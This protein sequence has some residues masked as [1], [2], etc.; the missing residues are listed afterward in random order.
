MRL[1]PHGK[2]MKGEGE[3]LLDWAAIGPFAKSKKIRGPARAVAALFGAIMGGAS[4]LGG[5][6]LG[7]AGGA[8]GAA[9]GSTAGG[10]G[11][12]L[13]EEAAALGIGNAYGGAAAGTA[14]ATGAGTSSMW[15]DPRTYKQ[16]ADLLRGQG[17]AYQAR[18][19]AYQQPSNTEMML[20][21]VEQERQEEEDRL[22]RQQLAQAIMSQ[23]DA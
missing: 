22:R 9:G 11:S 7:G 6:A 5:S 18:G 3:S 13:A 21:R 20:A 23:Y 1:L 17:G 19:G 12:G 4:A 2:I 14:G 16:M 8:G 10:L 15:K